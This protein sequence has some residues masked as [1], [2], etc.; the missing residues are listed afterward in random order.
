V[1]LAEY[2]TCDQTGCWVNRPVPDQAAV[3]WGW[4]SCMLHLHCDT[5]RAAG[6]TSYVHCF[7]FCRPLRVA[8][9]YGPLAVGRWPLDVPRARARGLVRVRA[10]RAA[11]LPERGLSSLLKARLLTSYLLN[12]TCRDAHSSMPAPRAPPCLP[13][14]EAANRPYLALLPPS[15]LSRSHHRLRRCCSTTSE[16]HWW[17]V[18][19]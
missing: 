18:R 8:T 13:L 16:N 4:G 14:M 7:F 9:T 10:V 15:R 19:V 6:S 12:K 11:G 17:R 3:S 2:T 1:R 5:S